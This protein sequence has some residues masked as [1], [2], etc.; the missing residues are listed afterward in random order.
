MEK[1]TFFTRQVPLAIA[2]GVLLFLASPGL[3]IPPVTAFF[4]LLPL[5][6]ALQEVQNT[7]RALLLG[8]IAGMVWYMPLLHWITIVLGTYGYMPL[9]LTILVLFLLAFYMS[10]Y[11]ALFTA[12]VFKWRRRTGGLLFFAPLLWVG[13]DY[14][15]SFL[16]TGFP[17]QDLGYSQYKNTWLIQVADLGGHHAVTWFLVLCNCLLFSLLHFVPGRRQADGSPLSRSKKRSCFIAVA[18]LLAVAG[19]NS[20]RLPDM[21]RKDADSKTVPVAVIQGN[22]E[23]DQKWLPSTKLSTVMAYLKLSADALSQQP[24]SLLIWPETAL[25]FSAEGHPYTNRIIIPFLKKHQTQLLTGTPYHRYDNDS[26]RMLL[27]NRALLL[28]T[29]V[30]DAPHYDKQ[31]LVPF[32][33]YIPFRSLLPAVSPVVQTMMDFMPGLHQVPIA[34]RNIRIGVLICFE[35]IFPELAR[36]H[37]IKGA[38]LLVNMTNDAWFGKSLAPAQHFSMGVFR[39]VENRRSFARAANTGISGFVDPAGRI[40]KVSPI[41]KATYLTASLPIVNEQTFFMIA[42]WAFA[43]GCLALAILLV[44]GRLGLPSLKESLDKRKHHEHRYR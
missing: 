6:F 43:P 7:G 17:W 41:F 36:Q 30:A 10:C 29:D 11:T 18:L 34:C 1:K 15:R 8:L 25:P 37:A 32:G 2:T 3:G 27:Y 20:W 31:H 42:G 35:S 16:F 26:Q 5:L 38:Q 12:I 22:I 21:E 4:G 40:M 14:L 24:K 19:Y 13:L 44:A 33:E 39:A 23:Q 9:S 28:G